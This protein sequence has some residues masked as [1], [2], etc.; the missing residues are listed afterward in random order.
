MISTGKTWVV[1][2]LPPD[3]PNVMSLIQISNG[4]LIDAE[5]EKIRPIPVF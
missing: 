1:H 4:D 3:A 5:T 2:G